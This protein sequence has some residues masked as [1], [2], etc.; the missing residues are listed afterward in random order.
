MKPFLFSISILFAAFQGISQVEEPEHVKIGVDTTAVE[1]SYFP[2]IDKFYEGEIP[3]E[4]LSDP[5]GIQVT[6]GWKVISFSISY[7]Y[8]NQNKVVPVRGN[9]IPTDII[10]DIYA[11]SLGEMIFITNIVTLNEENRRVHLVPMSLVPVK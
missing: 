10:K 5:K 7:P 9:T 6:E 4:Y 2:H 8:G 11:N 3:V 1:I